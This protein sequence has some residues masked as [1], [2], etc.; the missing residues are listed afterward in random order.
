MLQ[1]SDLETVYCV[2][3]NLDE[4]DE[5]SL[6]ILLYKLKSLFFT[7]FDSN[8]ICYL[9]IIIISC[10]LSDFYSKVLSSFLRI[11]LDINVD[12][13]INHN[14]HQF[15]EVKINKL[16]KLERYSDQLCVYVKDVFKKQ[17]QNTF[18]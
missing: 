11:T 6:K 18:L 14:V 7:E 13:E 3:D 17:V 12:A 8:M 9:K 2:L 5:D 1:D 15:I 16:F 4:C 10:D